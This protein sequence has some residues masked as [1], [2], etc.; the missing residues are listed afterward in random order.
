MAG[1]GLQRLVPDQVDRKLRHAQR[2]RSIISLACTISG[3]VMHRCGPPLASARS[4]W[5]SRHSARSGAPPSVRVD[6]DVRPHL[7][8]LLGACRWPHALVPALEQRISR[9]LAQPRQRI[10]DRGL[11]QA[12]PASDADG[13]PITYES[14]P[15][16]LFRLIAL[17]PEETRG[18]V[19]V[20]FQLDRPPGE[21]LGTIGSRM[22]PQATG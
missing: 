6:A 5:P 11:R 1:I 19:Q 20:Q 14:G 3:N 12:V 8:R 17:S 15:R 13:I 9:A 18:F 21:R 2:Q 4:I 22:Q 7:G 10:A 16:E